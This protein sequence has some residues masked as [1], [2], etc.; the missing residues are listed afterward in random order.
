MTDPAISDLQQSRRIIESLLPPAADVV[1]HL[2]PS[3]LPAAYIQLLDSAYGTVQDGD[4]LYAKVLD[5]FQ[6]AGEKPSPYLQRLQ[7]ALNLAVKRGSVLSEEVNKHL[8]TQFCKGC[9]DNSLLTELLL[10]QKKTNT[11]SFAKLL[12]LLRT[13][14]DCQAAKSM[15]M[16]QYSGTTRQRATSH[17]QTAYSCEGEKGTWVALSTLTQGLSRQVAE[18]QSQLATLTT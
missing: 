9:W 5:T 17:V 7:V 14:E 10:K 3:C 18:I 4:E 8:L 16:R 11:A 1:K 6:D 2:S 15:R 13:E 12:L